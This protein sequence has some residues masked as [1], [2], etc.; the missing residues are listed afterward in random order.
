MG[1]KILGP[2]CKN[3]VTLERVTRDAVTELGID[4]QITKVT[5]YA[6]IAACGIMSTPGLVVDEQIVLSGRVPTK[7]HVKELLAPS[8]G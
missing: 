5:D 4:A 6:E 2:G 7:G 3:C 8:A 1:R